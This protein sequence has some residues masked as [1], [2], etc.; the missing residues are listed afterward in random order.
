MLRYASWRR[1]DPDFAKLPHFENRVPPQAIVRCNRDKF[2]EHLK[3]KRDHCR[4]PLPMYFC[5]QLPTL[6]EQP[7]EQ[8]DQG[9]GENNV[10]NP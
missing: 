7:E 4:P 9:K 3:G 1:T 10:Q 6:P 2:C 8:R 5:G